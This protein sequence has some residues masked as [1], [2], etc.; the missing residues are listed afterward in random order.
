VIGGGDSGS[1]GDDATG[2]TKPVLL[3]PPAWCMTIGPLADLLE[4]KGSKSV[5]G[6]QEV[7]LSSCIY[8]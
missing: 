3:L 5:T 4:L 1:G 2:P 6:Q 7:L 8:G